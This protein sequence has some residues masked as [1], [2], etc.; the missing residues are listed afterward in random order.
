M[1]QL[2]FETSDLARMV[3][4]R[5]APYVVTSR[6]AAAMHYTPTSQVQL[7]AR[8]AFQRRNMYHDCT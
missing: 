8:L 3:I 7:N 4:N 6:R 1:L 5:K 2:Q